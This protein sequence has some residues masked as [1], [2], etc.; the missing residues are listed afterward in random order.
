MCPCGDPT[1]TGFASKCSNNLTS[2]TFGGRDM[3]L[4]LCNSS[5]LIAAVPSGAGVGYQLSVTVALQT[6]VWSLN[7]FSY[8]PPAITALSG[9]LT[10]P[11]TGLYGSSSQP[12]AVYL[13]GT[14]FGPPTATVTAVYTTQ[15]GAY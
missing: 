2:V 9:N 4:L 10:L 1:G 8:A 15:S 13:T 12:A 6:A 7:S 3:T 11:T 5:T 14:N